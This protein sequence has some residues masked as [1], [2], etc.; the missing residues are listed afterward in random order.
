MILEYIKKITGSTIDFLYSLTCGMKPPKMVLS[1]LVQT[2]GS[3]PPQFQKLVGR[4][5][6]IRMGLIPTIR[7]VLGPLGYNQSPSVQN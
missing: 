3:E 2:D 4:T 6:C 7:A 1:L 5:A